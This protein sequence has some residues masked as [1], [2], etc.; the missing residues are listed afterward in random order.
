M[1]SRA[2]L[3]ELKP[4]LVPMLRYEGT[5]ISVLD[6]GLFPNIPNVANRRFRRGWAIE[7]GCVLFELCPHFHQTID[8]LLGS[9]Q[10][11][12][13]SETEST[14]KVRGVSIRFGLCPTSTAPGEM[15][16]KRIPSFLYWA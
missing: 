7:M 9:Y 16:R 15:A 5:T 6:T 2:G 10:R 4:L 1:D 3:T 12:G 11:G 8:L 13:L 14:V